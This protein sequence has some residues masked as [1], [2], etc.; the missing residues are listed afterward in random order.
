M[1]F[2]STSSQSNPLTTPSVTTTIAA[3]DQVIL[4]KKILHCQNDKQSGLQEFVRKFA[5]KNFMKPR[6]FL[7]SHQKCF[8]QL[9]MV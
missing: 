5:R 2:P 6:P 1:K 9:Q 3:A 8:L 4:I 7:F